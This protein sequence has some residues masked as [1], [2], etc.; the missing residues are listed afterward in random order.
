MKNRLPGRF[1][2]RFVPALGALVLLAACATTAR[3]QQVP[4]PI[5]PGAAS[6]QPQQGS[7]TDANRIV[8]SATRLPVEED[9]S[10]AD[11]TVIP[12][13][14]LAERQTDRVADAL[15]DVPGLVVAQTG[16][17]GQLTSV[18]IRGLESQHT[19]VLIDGVPINQGLDGAFNF[20]DLTGD[21][22]NRIEVDRGPQSTLY[23]PSALAGTIQLFTRR[24]DDDDQAKPFTF[25]AAS[26]GG[27]F[28]TYRERF[29]IA[30]VL[31]AA[32]PAA[33]SVTSAKDG[34]DGKDRPAP[35]APADGG[36]GVF[37]YSV[38]FSRVDTDNDRQNNDYRNTAVLA[39]VGFAPNAF[40][41]G[42][43]GGKAPR[44][45]LLVT[46][47][48][49]VAASPDDIYDFRPIDRLTTE[50]Q[51]YAPNVD[52][53]VTSWWHQHLVLDYDTERQVDNPNQD[54]F[55]GPTRGQ[56]DRYQLDDQ[57]DF[58]ITRWLTLTAGVF[59]TQDFAAQRQPFVSQTFGPEPQYTKDY[60]DEVGVF[61]QLSITPFKNALLVGGGRYDDFNRFGGQGT[62]RVAGSY[63]FASTGTTVRSS[64]ATGFS[65]PTPQDRIFG[66]NLAL[67]P[68]RDFGY[69]FG[70]EQGAFKDRL[71]FGSNYFHND[72][73]NTIGYT[74]DFL[75]LEN[76]GSART[77]GI[78]A[79]ARW[80]PVSWLFLHASYTWLDAVSTSNA[81]VD[82]PEGSRL[83]RQPR[84]EFFASLG[85]RPYKGLSVA[86][87]VK[88][89]NA[90]EDI[91][92]R[93][94]A[95]VDS[96]DY[97]VL[98][99]LADYAVTS[100]LHVYGRIENLGGEHYQE[101]LG[102]PALGRGFFGGAAVHF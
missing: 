33:A 47:S 81:N 40:A 13:E 43:L 71:R 10:P 87:E 62:Y 45:G 2:P 89:V 12:A 38:A 82:L 99:L 31:G 28:D 39:N 15:R 19:Q 54:G 27:T 3:A 1:R 21:G 24:G 70:F 46:Y 14:E 25:D 86:M 95:R 37:D 5:S 75:Q 100:H 4:S 50:R 94:F 66:N 93:T 26:E 73:T 7:D 64:V 32:H 63:L 97:T 55:Y 8:V 57:N 72:L 34:K 17:P 44:F 76:L 67:A 69:D 42:S 90:R 29:D 68:E 11:V 48:D 61:G 83:L 52:W 102:Y 22:L 84:N 92:P 79:F 77:L 18:F 35:P 74:S 60:T 41:L 78:E 9:Q 6:D 80:E 16:S 98:R 53:Q 88:E 96:P 91:D 101:V 58:V 56:F 49:S 36:P 59:Y 51:L 65:P 85:V 20:A 23:G 30:G